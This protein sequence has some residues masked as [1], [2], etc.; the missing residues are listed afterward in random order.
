M[1][2]LHFSR[3]AGWSISDHMRTDLVTDALEAAARTRG[4]SLDLAIF[5]SDNGAQYVSKE[6]A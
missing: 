3:L 2:V 6:L 1:L 4:G 5:H